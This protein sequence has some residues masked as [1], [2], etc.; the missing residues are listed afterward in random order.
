M[1][2]ISEETVANFRNS[3]LLHILAVSGGHTLYIIIGATFLLTKLK[4]SKK[5][6]N[7]IIIVILLLFM[8]ITGLNASVVRACIMGV[9]MVLSKVLYRKLDIYTSIGFSL[10]IVFVDNPFAINDIGLQ[11]SYIGTLGIVLLNKPIEDFLCKKNI[12][13][14][15]AQGLSVTISAQI[16]LIPILIYNF[17]TMSLTFFISNMLAL[18]L[19]GAIMGIGAANIFISIFSLDLAK[20]T[21]VILNFLLE[22][23]ILI[24]EVSSK[25]PFSNIVVI[26]PYKITIIIYYIIIFLILAIYRLKTYKSIKI[27]ILSINKNR[28]KL[29]GVLLIIIIIFNVFTL[30]IKNINSDLRIHFIDV[31]Q[32]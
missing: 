2:D 23:L 11:L 15:I 3:S 14:K 26:T 13:K 29:I 28:K 5:L 6:T 10:L 24:A 7:F 25:I 8:I 18:P 17:N 4:I 20:F 22:I 16:L 9:I 27:L 30:I 19:I 32:R 1:T 31:G 21:S 12:N